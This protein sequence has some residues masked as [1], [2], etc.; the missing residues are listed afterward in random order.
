MAA[1]HPVNPP[2]SGTMS[3]WRLLKRLHRCGSRAGAAPDGEAAGPPS[4]A[5]QVRLVVMPA[6][7]CGVHQRSSL[8]A[9][10]AV[11]PS[12]LAAHGSAHVSAAV[13]LRDRAQLH[14]CSSEYM[15]SEMSAGKD[16][17]LTRSCIRANQQLINS[18]TTARHRAGFVSCA[19][20]LH[21]ATVQRAT[22]FSGPALAADW[23]VSSLYVLG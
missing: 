16:M 20:G 13:P 3:S 15:A 22:V 8:R 10:L 7:R 17:P 6:C 4:V 21:L 11:S 19:V 9:L 12:S 2:C 23:F 1:L 18:C 5:H 14:R